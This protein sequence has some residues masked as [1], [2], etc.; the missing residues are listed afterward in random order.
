MK[1][2]INWKLFLHFLVAT[3]LLISCSDDDNDNGEQEPTPTISEIVAGDESFQTLLAALEAAEL[4]E[5]LAGEGPFTV[6]A[7]SDEAFAKL[8]EGT[9]ESLLL[10]ENRNQLQNILL[11]HVVP[12]EFEASAV[13]GESNLTSAFGQD[14]TID[15]DKVQISGANIVTT[16]IRAANGV[17]HVID[18]VLLPK[19]IME[20]A[21][22]AGFSTLV[23]AID[24]ADLRTTLEGEGPFTV[25]APTDDA[26]AA[27][28]EGTLDSLLLPENQQQL[29]DILSYHVVG[30]RLL[31]ED[32]LGA[33]TLTSL[34]GS[35]ISVSSDGPKVDEATIT[36]TDIIA[37]NGVI[38][39]I[40][41]VIL[42]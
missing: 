9:L 30:E 37:A 29:I 1:T 34:Q 25:F 35:E 15:S 4:T 12:G 41:A 16:D 40:D 26:F 32:V 22:G 38:H 13:L 14:L 3:S 27:L 7:P 17:I 24:A 8:P 18:T 6:F 20:L 11:F 39:V 31:A 2:L 5:T 42:P 28:P 21:E 10:E 33:N 23:A 19:N 36:V